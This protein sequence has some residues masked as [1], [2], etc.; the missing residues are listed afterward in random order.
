MTTDYKKLHAR[1]TRDLEE[2]ENIFDILPFYINQ[3]DGD[4]DE[5][6]LNNFANWCLLNQ[7]W[8]DKTT[9][10]VVAADILVQCDTDNPP[11]LSLALAVQNFCWYFS[12]ACDDAGERFI[13]DRSSQMIHDAIKLVPSLLPDY[14][15]KYLKRLENLEK[16]EDDE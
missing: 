14:E 4:F 5:S 3:E 16:E 1:I 11:F 2:G 7:D 9:L 12:M 6:G 10:Q 8:E 13:P 15:N